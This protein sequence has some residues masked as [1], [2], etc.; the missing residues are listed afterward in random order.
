MAFFSFSYRLDVQSVTSF[1]C[2]YGLSFLQ[3]S[4]INNLTN[5]V[6]IFKTSKLYAQ[7]CNICTH[8]NFGFQLYWWGIRKC[9]YIWFP[10]FSHGH[11]I[12]LWAFRTPRMHPSI[13]HMSQPYIFKSFQ[14]TNLHT[15][16]IKHKHHNPINFL[17]CRPK[18]VLCNLKR[19]EKMRNLHWKIRIW[20]YICRETHVYRLIR[21]LLELYAI[22]DRQRHGVRSGGNPIKP[23]G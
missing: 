18:R 14:S 4:L 7:F 22:T 1:P 6:E 15:W 2:F 5:K 8:E 19:C 10:Y 17:N 13:D 12:I 3:R 23:K 21:K 20:P 16:S 9:M 11:F